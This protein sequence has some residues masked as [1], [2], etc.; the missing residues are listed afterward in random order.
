MFKGRWRHSDVAIKQFKIEYSESKKELR[1]FI[2]ELSVLMTVRHPYILLLMGVAIDGPNLCF[3]TEF[4]D[5]NSLFYALH[6][7]KKRTVHFI[8]RLKIAL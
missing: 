4:I 6:K 5:N 8:E 2:K 7:N 1:K 3:I